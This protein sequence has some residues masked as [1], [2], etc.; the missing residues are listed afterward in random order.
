MV[1]N[2]KM[3][4]LQSEWDKKKRD[5]E[6]SARQKYNTEH[7][8]DPRLDNARNSYIRV[9]VRAEENGRCNL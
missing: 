6:V 7:G 5:I 2:G 8:F 3:I 4:I 1:Q 9:E